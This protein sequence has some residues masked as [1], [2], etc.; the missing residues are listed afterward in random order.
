MWVFVC[1]KAIKN[2]NSRGAS[3]EASTEVLVIGYQ[4]KGAAFGDTMTIEQ[5]A[6][7][8]RGP[9]V[10]I[11]PDDP[12]SFHVNAKAGNMIKELNIPRE[13]WEFI[14]GHGQDVGDDQ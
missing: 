7:R 9:L 6:A 2:G 11:G 14:D 4:R 13:R 8:W 1:A 5:F 3:D 12:H 10:L